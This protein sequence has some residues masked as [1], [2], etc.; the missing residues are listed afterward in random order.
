MFKDITN[1][2]T[3][4][5][6]ICSLDVVDHSQYKDDTGLCVD[7]NILN[8]HTLYHITY[9]HTHIHISITNYYHYYT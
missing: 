1:L 6:R 4:Q 9:T 8:L 5:C 3:G 7:R 2:C